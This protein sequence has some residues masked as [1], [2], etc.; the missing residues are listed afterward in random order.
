MNKFIKQNKTYISI[1]VVVIAI[2]TI[3]YF[4][5]D[6]EEGDL[7]LG[8]FGAAASGCLKPGKYYTG[9]SLKNIDGV[10][11]ASECAKKCNG[12][13]RCVGFAYHKNGKCR[14]RK[15]IISEKNSIYQV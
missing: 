6:T 12:E 15:K 9:W 7:T 11:S 3:G 14:L 13:S 10:S 8:V 5:Y 1:A 4:L 2:L